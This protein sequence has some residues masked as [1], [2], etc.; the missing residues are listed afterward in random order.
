MQEIDRQNIPHPGSRASF[1]TLQGTE[2]PCH[3]NSNEATTALPAISWSRSNGEADVRHG[4]SLVN[5]A[6]ADVVHTTFR[7][8]Q[9]RRIATWGVQDLTPCF[10]WAHQTSHDTPWYLWSS[11]EPGNEAQ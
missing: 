5:T 3:V 10:R 11:A 8:S 7:I 2:S 6:A 9:Q 4:I 1:K